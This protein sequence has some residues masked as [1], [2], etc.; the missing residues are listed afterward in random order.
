MD[1]IAQISQLTVESPGKIVLVVMDGL[2]G[3]PHPE[4]GKTELETAKTPNLDKLAREGMCGLSEP[5]CCHCRQAWVSDPRVPSDRTVTL[6]VTSVG[7]VKPDPR[8]PS[9]LRPEGVVR[10]PTTREPSTS[11]ASAG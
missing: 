3:L 8:E 5:P 11:S 4:T 6:A 10:T 2:G 1:R 9:R 7:G